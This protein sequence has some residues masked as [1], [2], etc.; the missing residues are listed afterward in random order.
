MEEPGGL[1]SIGSRRVRHD[2]ATSLSRISFSN[3]WKWNLLSRVWLFA[4]LWTA[5]YQAPLPMGFSRQEYWSGVPLPSPR[6]WIVRTLREGGVKNYFQV[7]RWKLG[8]KCKHAVKW[9]QLEQQQVL[10]NDY[11]FSWRILILLSDRV[12]KC[13][14]EETTRK[15]N[16]FI[17]NL[18]RGVLKN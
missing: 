16:I 18:R 8:W 7:L 12:I 15:R 5:A 11:T 6:I 4:T 2:W 14:W 17:W 13:H 1:Q 3:A 9:G 10:G